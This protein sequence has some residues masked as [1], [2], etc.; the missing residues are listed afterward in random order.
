MAKIEPC[1][2]PMCPVKGKRQWRQLG[3]R[4][5]PIGYKEKGLGFVLGVF[6]VP[7]FGHRTR[8]TGRLLNHSTLSCS[9]L[10]WTALEQHDLTWKSFFGWG[11]EQNNPQKSLI[12]SIIY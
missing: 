10:D 2:S 1:L 9:E 4:E 6:F 5:I 12:V 11:F 7:I 8:A 3:A